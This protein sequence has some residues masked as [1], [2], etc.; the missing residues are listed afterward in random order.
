MAV[1]ACVT[2]CPSGP[3][4]G[5]SPRGPSGWTTETYD[6]LAISIPH[7]WKV[8]RQPPVCPGA[9]RVG[10]LLLGPIQ[11]AGC[12]PPPGMHP[13][14]VIAPNVVNVTSFSGDSSLPEG[15]H[16]EVING[17]HVNALNQMALAWWLP[18]LGLLVSGSG[19]EASAVMHTIRPTTHV[20]IPK[21]WKSYTYSGATISV[22]KNWTVEHNTS[23]PLSTSSGDLLL[24]IPKVL[25]HCPS[26][27]ASELV[28]LNHPTTTRAQSGSFI[29][30]NG[31]PVVVMGSPADYMVWS[32][33][34]LGIDITAQGPK[35]LQ[36][37]QTLRRS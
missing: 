34:S 7:T 11:G 18:N 21:G 9:A 26:Y 23:C 36:I 12:P 31:L 15:Y 14:Y 3:A 22:P 30:V 19:P 8:F 16:S 24:G 25:M 33:P 35:A 2:L 29:K 6:G 28:E 20:A 1:A 13:P 27:S 32:V 37:L 4:A 5:S 10:A 17:L